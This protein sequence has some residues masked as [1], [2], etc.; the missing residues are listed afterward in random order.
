MPLARRMPKRGFQPPRRTEYAILNLDALCRFEPGTE[1]T[2]ELVQKVGLVRNIRDGLKIL[3]TGSID[4]PLKVRAHR[5]SQT[6]RARI[7]E[8]GGTCEEIGS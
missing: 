7:E 4:R 2:P 1:V 3:G 5:F 6:A 8:A